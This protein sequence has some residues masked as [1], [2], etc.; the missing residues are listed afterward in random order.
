MSVPY[1]CLH[2]YPKDT[3]DNFSEASVLA[4]TTLTNL[5]ELIV[6]SITAFLGSDRCFRRFVYQTSDDEVGRIMC[7]QIHKAINTIN[8]ISES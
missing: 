8:F 6:P 4:M 7:N 5:I 3:E 2:F 1:L